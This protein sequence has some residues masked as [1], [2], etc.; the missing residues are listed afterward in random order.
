MSN[1]T[2]SNEILPNLYIGSIEA[3]ENFDFIEK[4]NISN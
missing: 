3:S 1:Y 2:F 4:K